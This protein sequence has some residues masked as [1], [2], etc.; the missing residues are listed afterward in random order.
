MVAFLALCGSF[1]NA[2]TF[3]QNYKLLTVSNIPPLGFGVLCVAV[4]L[5]ANKISG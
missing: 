4:C 3:T 2:V 1:P 5:P